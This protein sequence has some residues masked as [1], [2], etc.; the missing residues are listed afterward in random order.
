MEVLE[1]WIRIAYA[2]FEIKCLAGCM[3]VLAGLSHAA[4]RRLKR[5]VRFPGCDDCHH[6]LVGR[7]GGLSLWWEVW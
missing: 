2:L 3:A 7:G 4:I 6:R 5:T 1:R